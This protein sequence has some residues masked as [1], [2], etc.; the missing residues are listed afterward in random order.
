MFKLLELQNRV[1]GAQ[2][3]KQQ[4]PIKKKAAKASQIRVF[5]DLQLYAEELYSF[6]NMPVKS[7]TTE[8]ANIN[9]D[10][11]ITSKTGAYKNYPVD[12]QISFCDSYPFSPPK[13]Y[14][15]SEIKHPNILPTR[16]ISLNIL[17]H[18]QP[19]YQFS[20]LVFGLL[21]LLSESPDYG[22]ILDSSFLGKPAEFYENE[23]KKIV[24][25][26]ILSNLENEFP[27]N[28]I[29]LSEENQRY[30]VE[31]IL[32]LNEIYFPIELQQILCMEFLAQLIRRS[33]NLNSGIPDRPTKT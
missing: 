19:V 1:Q 17:Y 30:F 20:T 23:A 22:C 16:R 21:N 7:V 13:V 11:T 5:Q 10:I 31:A 8:E 27:R 15:L 12:F 33:F 14:C 29:H 3:Q 18:W 9:V 2:R 4:A 24:G 26:W 25:K 6:E 32:C 28:V